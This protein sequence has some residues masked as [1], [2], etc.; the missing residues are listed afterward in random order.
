MTTE[1]NWM[2]PDELR[3]IADYCEA[4]NPLWDALT[5]GP[6]GGVTVDCESLKVAVYDSN[7]DAL[8]RITWGDSGPAFYLAIP[9]A[10][11]RAADGPDG[12]DR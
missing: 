10:T 1:Q 7:G 5:T 2:A 8:G 11:D 12:A 6:K 4:L 3:A 9:P